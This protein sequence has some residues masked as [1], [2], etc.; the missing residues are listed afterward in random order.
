MSTNKICS[1]ITVITQI[2][3]Y[4]DEFFQENLVYYSFVRFIV[5]RSCMLMHEGFNGFNVQCNK[6]TSY[7]YGL[8]KKEQ[9][10]RQLLAILWWNLKRNLL[11][12]TNVYIWRLLFFFTTQGNSNILNP[13]SPQPMLYLIK[14][15]FK[16]QNFR[17]F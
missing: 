7:T 14:N 9:W 16:N 5:F 17:Y 1:R 6:V 13:P 10:N 15:V 3:H 4:E 11:F 12:W 2:R 8:I